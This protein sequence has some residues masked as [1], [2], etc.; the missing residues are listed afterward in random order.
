[1]QIVREIKVL[2]SYLED[3]R[4][5]GLSVGFVPTMGALHN[6]HGELIKTS[7]KECD[8]TVCSIF[9]NPTQFDNSEDLEKYPRMEAEDFKL[10]DELG[11]DLVFIPS[12]DEMYNSKST[13]SFYFGN[14]E[15]TMEGTF[16]PGHFNGVA[17]IVSKLFNIVQ[18]DRA[19]FGQKDLQQ[20]AVIRKLVHDLSFQL[21]VIGVPTVREESGLAMSS[22][23]KRLSNEALAR[24]AN[25]NKSLQR[26][27]N[28]VL[29]GSIF[30]EI[31]DQY[32]ADLAELNIQVEY[33]ELVDT[34][35]LEKIQNKN[36]NNS[37]A[38]CIAA[39][40]DGVRLIDNRIF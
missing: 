16:R 31:K 12:V 18:P 35:S 29:K 36:G 15:S 25:I 39:I 3:K 5:N 10:L 26:I 32:I 33:L 22:R 28:E 30:E 21:K 4:I 38:V 8:Y 11:C 19:Y 9:V 6:G 40:V 1:M 27:E 37:V 14:L 23:N 20:L 7:K 17:L 13:L 2:K 24:A 34:D